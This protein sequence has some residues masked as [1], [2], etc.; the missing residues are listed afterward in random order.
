M[1]TDD[2]PRFDFPGAFDLSGEVAVVTGGSRGIGRAIA[3]GLAAAGAA[4]APV[5]RTESD[6]AEVAAELDEYGAETCVA[7]A[8]VADEADV[9][10]CFET[11]AAE[12]GRPSVV[13]N[14]AGINPEAALGTPDRV[15]TDGFD[16]VNNVNLRGAYACAHAAAEHLE[17]TGGSLVNVAS[18]GGLVGLPRQHPYVA[19]KHGLVG[20]TKSLALDWA[21][22]VRANC[23][24]PGYV[25]TDL[26][27]DLTGNEELAA[28]IRERTPLDRFA[29]PEEVAGPAVFLASPAASYLTGATISVDGGWTAR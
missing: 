17:A 25:A 7:T 11:V 4:V 8:D 14:N 29:D 12:L 3:H 21:P 27:E 1:D 10:D 26:T 28:S 23:L 2:A 19:S 20:L 5:S 15:D 24:A 6:V 13:V 18:V 16:Q 9:L 22:D